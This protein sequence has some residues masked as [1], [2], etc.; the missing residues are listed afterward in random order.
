[1]SVMLFQSGSKEEIWNVKVDWIVVEESEVDKYLKSGWYEH[2]HDIPLEDPE[3]EKKVA[4]WGN[5]NEDKA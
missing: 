2:V 5:K 4:K 1:M 3:L